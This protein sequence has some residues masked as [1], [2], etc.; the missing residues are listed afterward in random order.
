MVVSTV[1]LSPPVEATR[2]LP[3]G[4]EEVDVTILK[5]IAADTRRL[6]ASVDHTPYISCQPLN[7]P[8]K[9]EREFYKEFQ[10]RECVHARCVRG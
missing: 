8:P 5:W 9:R 7:L 6:Y 4:F 2:L 1:A 10:G 3:A